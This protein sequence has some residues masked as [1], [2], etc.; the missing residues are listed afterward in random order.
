MREKNRV[1]GGGEGKTKLKGK[2]VRNIVSLE[3]DLRYLYFL[4]FFC[5]AKIYISLIRNSTRGTRVRDIRVDIGID[6]SIYS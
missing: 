4:F 5:S 1:F 3:T 6:I 2:G